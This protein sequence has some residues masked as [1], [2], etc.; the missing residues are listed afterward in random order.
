MADALSQ[1]QGPGEQPAA[2]EDL[3]E[4]STLS[5]EL[6]EALFRTGTGSH[7]EVLDAQRPLCAARQASINRRLSEQ[8]RR[9]VPYKA[10]GGGWQAG[11]PW[12]PAVNLGDR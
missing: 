3:V 5:H 10:V 7:A 8:P 6:S 12:S 9:I 11:A 1:R 4:S 2:Q